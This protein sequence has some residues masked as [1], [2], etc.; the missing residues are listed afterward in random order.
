MLYL[1]NNFLSSVV[2]VKTCAHDCIA[3]FCSKKRKLDFFIISLHLKIIKKEGIVSE[4]GSNISSK[5]ESNK[6]KS[7]QTHQLCFL[8][9][10]IDNSKIRTHKKHKKINRQI[11]IF[12]KYLEFV[13]FSLCC[14][15]LN[16]N[17]E[18]NWIL[19]LKLRKL[20][21]LKTS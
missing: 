9:F 18:K 19:I 5:W 16:K 15:E 4:M 13:S 2:R 1:E 8:T 12:W 20:R 11:L 21:K 14:F 6:R 17:K 10:K 7:L 3:A